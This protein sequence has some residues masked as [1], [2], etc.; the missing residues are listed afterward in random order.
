MQKTAKLEW[1]GIK[2]EARKGDV[3]K[4]EKQKLIRDFLG[5]Y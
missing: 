4:A 3:S 1:A 5:D 2:L